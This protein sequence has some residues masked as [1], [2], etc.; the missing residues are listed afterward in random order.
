MTEF[1]HEDIRFSKMYST[2]TLNEELVNDVVCETTSQQDKLSCQ[3]LK[4]S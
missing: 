3:Y 2:Q 1:Q 4:N